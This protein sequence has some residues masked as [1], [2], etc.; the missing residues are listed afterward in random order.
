MI[1]FCL[2][3]LLLYIA[4][5]PSSKVPCP[6]CDSYA[7]IEQRG[8]GSHFKTSVKLCLKCKNRFDFDMDRNKDKRP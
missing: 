8:D 6:K 7:V 5:I 3:I 1:S 4:C 2:L